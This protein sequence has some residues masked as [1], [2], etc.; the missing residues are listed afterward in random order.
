MEIMNLE[1]LSCIQ[2][3]TTINQRRIQ[4]ITKGLEEKLRSQRNSGAGEIKGTEATPTKNGDSF[5]KGL[6]N[7]DFQT[8]TIPLDEN[9]P[10]RILITNKKDSPPYI[11]KLTT[12]EILR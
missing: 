12:D 7:A 4:N 5:D 3:E 6:K 10:R 2:N 8:N 9:K 11:S 1:T